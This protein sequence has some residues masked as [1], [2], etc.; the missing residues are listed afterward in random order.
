MLVWAGL[1]A[2][3]ALATGCKGSTT[4]SARADQYTCPM[5]PTV[6]SSTQGACPVCGMDL[7]RKAREGEEVKITEDL[8]RL[9]T[10]PDESVVAELKTI[11]GT[12]RSQP[13][14]LEAPGAVGYDT[15]YLHIVPSRVAGRVEKTYLRNAFQPVHKGQKVA[16]I[17]SPEMLTAQRELLFLATQDT[18]TTLLRAARE[19]LLLLGATS[20]QIDQWLKK[21]ET[22]PWI[23]VVSGVDG[24]VILPKSSSMPA[25]LATVP[26]STGSMG[27]AGMGAASAT[28]SNE[29][30]VVAGVM[31]REGDY[32]ARGQT[33][34]T[35]ASREALRVEVSVPA[36]Q[37]G[38]VKAGDPVVVVPDGQNEIKARVDLVQPFYS[39]GAY[40]LNVRVNLRSTDLRIGQ[41][42]VV[43]FMSHS[44]ES[45][46]LPKEAT[47]DL[48]TTTVVFV[49][50]RGTFK[51]RSIV[52][53][54]RANGWVEV[55]KGLA[56]AEEVAAQAAYLVDSESFIK[57]R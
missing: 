24:Y 26:A 2:V 18:D 43:K 4:D 29:P 55:L 44:A 46:W 1:L 36:D 9:L 28:A 56:S 6:V 48:G 35:I 27:T 53:G 57:N 23:T 47:Y 21:G 3:L 8:A 49:K 30:A 34:F 38:H 16:E 19:K 13:I 39:D 20:P 54:D 12:Y 22:D 52:A 10:S 41:L 33:L 40:F 11:K 25:R 17:Y 5:H 51:A 37:A 50:E 7:V 31:V 45:L 32:V 14:A 15:R 42:A